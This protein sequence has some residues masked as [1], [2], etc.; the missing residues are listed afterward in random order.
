MA[1][2]SNILAWR[3]PWTEEPGG[4]QSRGWQSVSTTE[5]TRVKVYQQQILL[6]SLL[7]TPSLPS[8]LQDSLAEAAGFV[9]R[10]SFSQPWTSVAPF[11]LVSGVSDDKAALVELMSIRRQF[12]LFLWLLSWFLVSSF[13]NLT[14][15]S[16][17]A[18][19]GLIL[20]R[21]GSAT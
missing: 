8:V 15:M 1:T 5:H 16:W 19:F 17:M 2:H 13:L 11:P 14:D 6:V 18:F 9:A 21:T 12:A 3:T 4:L 10:R 7:R 20:V